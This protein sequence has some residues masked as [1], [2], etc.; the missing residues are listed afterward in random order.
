MV[1]VK[2]FDP[3]HPGPKNVSGLFSAE[4]RSVSKHLLRKMFKYS[5]NKSIYSIRYFPNCGQISGQ[6]ARTG[7]RDIRECAALCGRSPKNRVFHPFGGRLEGDRRAITTRTD[8]FEETA[9]YPLS[10][11][12][13]NNRKNENRE[14]GVDFYISKSPRFI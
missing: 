2:G 10:L 12:K 3:R 1:G 11:T 6:N 14:S 7:K 8:F 5:V 13:I 4:N 9:F